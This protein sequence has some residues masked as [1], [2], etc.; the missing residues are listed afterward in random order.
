VA[1]GGFNYL[2]YDAALTRETNA[3]GA[4]LALKLAGGFV[5]VD[6]FACGD[7]VCGGRSHRKAQYSK[8]R[9]RGWLGALG[10]W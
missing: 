3:P 8:M 7:A 1:N 4:K 5:N 9:R 6:A 2:N 10:Y